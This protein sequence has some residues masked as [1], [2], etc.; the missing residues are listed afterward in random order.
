MSVFLHKPANQPTYCNFV[1][2]VFVLSHQYLSV[3]LFRILT[4][5]TRIVFEAFVGGPFVR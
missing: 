5:V 3:F 4:L 1:V 2:F